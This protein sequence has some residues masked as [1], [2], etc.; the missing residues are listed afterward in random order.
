MLYKTFY[1]SMHTTKTI[2]MFLKKNNKKKTTKKR[3]SL[4]VQNTCNEA[5]LFLNKY[6][7]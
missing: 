2:P 4:Y 5:S 6:Q 3:A 7:S 1:Y